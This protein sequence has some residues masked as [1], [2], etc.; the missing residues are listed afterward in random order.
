MVLQGTVPE[1]ARKVLGGAYRIRLSGRFSSTTEQSPE[2]FTRCQQSDAHRWNIRKSEAQK[3]VRADAADAVIKAGGRLQSLTV[4]L[5]SLD[6]I[7]TH[8]FEEVNN[9]PVN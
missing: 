7:Y 2:K 8:Y 5:Q 4:E 6:D 9:E 3:D 1:L